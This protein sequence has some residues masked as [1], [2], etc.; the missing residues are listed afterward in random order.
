MFQV[1]WYN[2]WQV[3]GTVFQKHCGLTVVWPVVEE[4]R[5]EALMGKDGEGNMPLS[6]AN[7]EEC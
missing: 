3:G 2:E 7:Y 1:K 4:V 5:R 6:V